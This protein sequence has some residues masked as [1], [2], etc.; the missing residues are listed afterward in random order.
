MLSVAYQPIE[1]LLGAFIAHMKLWY[2]MV[3]KERN[4]MG[5]PRDSKR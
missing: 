3:S 2:L 4:P 1:E 5:K